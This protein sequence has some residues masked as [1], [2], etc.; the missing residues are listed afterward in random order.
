MY[1]KGNSLGRANKYYMAY[2]PNHTL[3][4]F[5]SINLNEAYSFLFLYNICNKVHEHM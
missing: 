4:Y 3:I 2:K 5:V 1:M